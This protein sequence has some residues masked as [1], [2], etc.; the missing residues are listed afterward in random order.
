MN[1]T[2]QHIIYQC[3]TCNTIGCKVNDCSN[4]II[5]DSNNPH[6]DNFEHGADRCIRCKNEGGTNFVEIQNVDNLI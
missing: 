1:S 5:L 4:Q 2:C 6:N 3:K